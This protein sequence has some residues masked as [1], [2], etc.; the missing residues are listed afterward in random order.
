MSKC[1]KCKEEI[2]LLNAYVYFGQDWKDGSYNIGDWI[3][4]HHG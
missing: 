3:M 2:N 1:K 4:S